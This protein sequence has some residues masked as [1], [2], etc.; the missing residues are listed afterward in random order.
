MYRIV[1]D[2]SSN[3]DAGVAELLPLLEE[4][5]SARWLAHQLLEGCIVSS[6]VEQKCLEIIRSLATGSSAEALGEQIWLKDYAT[7]RGNV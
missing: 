3:G 5:E 1:E 2:A 7:K 6:M 4:P